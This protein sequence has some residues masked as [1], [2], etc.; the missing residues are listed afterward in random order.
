MDP[1]L[2]ALLFLTLGVLLIGIEIVLIPGVG[3]VGILGA[4]LMLYGVYL[5]WINYGAAWGMISLVGGSL[6]AG[7]TIYGFMK[8]PLSQR[9][10]LRNQQE[11]EPS[12]L[13]KRAAQLVGQ[14]GIALTDL[15]PSGIAKIQEERLDVVALD[16]EYIEKDENIQVVR[17]AQNSVLVTRIEKESV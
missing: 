17:I 9:L 11:G 4:A 14:Q 13:P 5:S 12:D 3:M 7:L 6:G 8:S 16:G 10:I 1:L 2:L 15:R